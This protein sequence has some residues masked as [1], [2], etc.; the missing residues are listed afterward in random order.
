FEQIAAIMTEF[1]DEDVVVEYPQSGERI[2]GVK[3]NLAILE[4]YPGRPDATIKAVH[5]A[6]DK[7]VL[8]PSWSALR[9]AG[10]GDH[11]S[12]EGRVTYPNGEV[13]NYVGLF[14]LRNDSVVKLTEYYAAPF[15]AAEWR[16]KWVEKAEA[17]GR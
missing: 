11:Y 2:R 4:N 5:G 9:I 12:V 17:S 1:S 14:E 7:W 16:A 15:P 13:W 6:E 8:T 10:S 3:N